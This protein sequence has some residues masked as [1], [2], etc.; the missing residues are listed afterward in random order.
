MILTTISLIQAAQVIQ[1]TFISRNTRTYQGK[2]YS[3]MKSTPVF[4]TDMR[5]VNHLLPQQ[6]NNQHFDF[7]QLHVGLVRSDLTFPTDTCVQL[8]NAKSTARLHS[9]YNI[10]Q[11]LKISLSAACLLIV[12]VKGKHAKAS[13]SLFLITKGQ[14]FERS[15]LRG[16]KLAPAALGNQI[17]DS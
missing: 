7:R 16:H 6:R 14:T 2:S 11:I 13:V 4:Q 8:M 9:L 1:S 17:S 5:S 12:N 10:P 15:F 3:N